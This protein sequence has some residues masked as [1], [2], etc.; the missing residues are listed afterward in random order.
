MTDPQSIPGEKPGLD[1]R[2]GGLARRSRQ[3]RARHGHQRRRGR[4]DRNPR[5]GRHWR[6]QDASTRD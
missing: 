1:D 3:S 2:D 6:D 4:T 5:R